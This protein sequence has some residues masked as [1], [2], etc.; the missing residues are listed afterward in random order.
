MTVNTQQIQVGVTNYIEAELAKKA[1]GFTKFAIYF[2]LPTITSKINNMLSTFKDN[3]FTN[4]FYDENGNIKLDEVYSAAK[5]AISKSGQIV[6]SGIIFSENDIDMLY[7]YITKA[8][9]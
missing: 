7:S 2:M 3:E 8:S 5:T 6:V 4:T 1:T 9:A